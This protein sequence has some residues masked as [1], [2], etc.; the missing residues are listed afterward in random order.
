MTQTVVR[1]WGDLDRF[2][3]GCS[4]TSESWVQVC[5]IV[6][7][8]ESQNH[9]AEMC[10]TPTT[11]QEFSSIHF[12]AV[13]WGVFLPALHYFLLIRSHTVLIPAPS[14]APVLLLGN[15]WLD[16]RWSVD[17]WTSLQSPC[18]SSVTTKSTLLSV[19]SQTVAN[20][21]AGPMFQPQHVNLNVNHSL[22]KHQPS[23]KASR[24]KSDRLPSGLPCLSPGKAT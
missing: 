24:P 8:T 4:S 14:P 9:W 13:K 18:I 20:S 22:T 15:Q 3:N 17:C 6:V 7:A 19:W 21:L 5:N 10:S 16:A 12:T 1:L 11:V 2:Y 23:S